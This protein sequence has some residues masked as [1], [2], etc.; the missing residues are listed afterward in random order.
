MISAGN[1][2]ETDYATDSAREEHRAD[3]DL[4]DLYADIARRALTFAY[5][6][7]LIAVLGVIEVNVNGNRQHK[8]YYDVKHIFIAADLRKPADLGALVYN[9]DLTCALGNFPYDN[10]ERNKLSCDVV[11]H[12]GEQGL[13][14]VPLCFEKRGNAAP[15]RA[16]YD[17][18]YGAYG[19]K[20]SVRDGICK[21][22]HAR[23]RRKAA[24]KDLALAAYVP[25]PHAERRSYGKRYAQEHCGIL[26][27]YPDLTLASE[28]AVYHGC[29]DLNGVFSR[30]G[31]RNDRADYK[32][33]HN[34]Q[35]AYAPCLVPRQSA[36]LNYV[37]QR[38]F[39]VIIHL[40]FPLPALSSS[41]RPHAFSHRGRE[42]CR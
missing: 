10:E 5:N 42:L 35:K 13:V 23:G 17:A 1:E 8:D 12:K 31:H 2:Q 36:A 21:A 41:C 18:G 27:E 15:D 9:T 6:G 28:G 38:L 16:C 40:P 19:D 26:G 4:F 39:A 7:K 25:E 32:C 11:H 30:H 24:G 29:I 20:Q 14:S 34:C 22:D 3:D 37:E 33:D